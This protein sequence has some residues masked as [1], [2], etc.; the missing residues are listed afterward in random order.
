MNPDL[1]IDGVEARFFVHGRMEILALLNEIIYRHEPVRI[2]FGAGENFVTQ[3]LE[4]RDQALV[5]AAGVDAGANARL[6]ASPS[7]LLLAWPDGIR[8][9]F[10]AGPVQPISW[11]DSAAFSVPI[12]DR[13]ARLQ[14]QESFRIIVPCA[15]SPRA[16][17]WSADGVPLG[18]WPVHDLSVGGLSVEVPSQSE[19]ALAPQVARVRL[20]LP[21]HGAIDSAVTLRHATALAQ[22]EGKLVYRIGVEFAGLPEP[23]RVAI[24]RYIV[25]VEQARRTAQLPPSEED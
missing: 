8:V 5:F 20:A 9:Q 3:L 22:R 17:L 12:P 16:T 1:N 10:A 21:G 15:G 24:Q 11:G 18:A 13:L 23:M 4:A 25:D 6:I 14:R 2:E 7:C 19:L